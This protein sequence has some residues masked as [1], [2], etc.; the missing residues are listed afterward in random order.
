MGRKRAEEALLH[1]KTEEMERG[2]FLLREPKGVPDVILIGTVDEADRLFSA[3][4]I[5][6]VQGITARLVAVSDAERFFAIRS[7]LIPPEIPC[8]A[9][10]DKTRPYET[11]AD[12]ALKRKAAQALQLVAERERL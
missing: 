11:G 1:V 4:D 7:G 9:V 3:A 6:A 5:L 10:S 2:G 12:S 8:A